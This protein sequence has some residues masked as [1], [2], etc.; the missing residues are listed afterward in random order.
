MAILIAP[1]TDYRDRFEQLTGR[2][3]RL[4]PVCGK[5]QMVR[6]GIV[7]A[8]RFSGATPIDSS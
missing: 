1:P 4:C 7:A 5:G 2:S 3:W 8:P 6:I